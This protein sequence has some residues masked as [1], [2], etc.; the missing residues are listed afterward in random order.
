MPPDRACRAPSE[1]RESTPPMLQTAQAPTPTS[2]VRHDNDGATQ[3]GRATIRSRPGEE[4]AEIECPWRSMRDTA[5]RTGPAHERY[6]GR[7]RPDRLRPARSEMS[8]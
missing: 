5:V 8:D 2:R 4:A 1:P 7:S 6:V 3:H